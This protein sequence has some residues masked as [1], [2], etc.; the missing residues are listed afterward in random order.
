MDNQ[1]FKEKS[2]AEFMAENPIEREW[3]QPGQKVE[4]T[5]VKIT[6]EWVFIDLGSKSEGYLDCKEF[7]DESGKFTISEG[8]KIKAYFL[9]L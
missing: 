6:P 7:L 9:Y 8:D 4:A 3:L 2:F 5:V 1:E